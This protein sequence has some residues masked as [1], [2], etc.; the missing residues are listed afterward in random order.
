MGDID[1]TGEEAQG[2]SNCRLSFERRLLVR[3]SI[4]D[5][6]KDDDTGDMDE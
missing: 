2:E 3:F 1:G 6:D 5:D 4:A